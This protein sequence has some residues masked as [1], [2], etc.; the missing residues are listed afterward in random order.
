MVRTMLWLVA[1]AI[2]GSLHRQLWLRPPPHGAQHK[3]SDPLGPR[4]S[5]HQ[6]GP[7]SRVHL[8]FGAHV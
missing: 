8:D 3:A 7:R 2:M 5:T 1:G 6:V 4:P